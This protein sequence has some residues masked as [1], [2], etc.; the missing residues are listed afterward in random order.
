MGRHPI[1]NMDNAKE[2]TLRV[3]SKNPNYTIEVRKDSPSGRVLATL[4]FKETVLP[5]IKYQVSMVAVQHLAKWDIR[6]YQLQLPEKLKGTTN[7]FLVFKG[8][9]IRVDTIQLR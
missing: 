7:L 9:D 6:R 4:S 5:P 3:A 2:I 1:V 8:K